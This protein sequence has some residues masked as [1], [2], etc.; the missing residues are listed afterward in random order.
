VKVIGVWDLK[1]G[2]QCRPNF[3]TAVAFQC[4]K[5]RLDAEFLELVGSVQFRWIFCG[6]IFCWRSDIFAAILRRKTV[7]HISSAS[8]Y[9]HLISK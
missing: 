9:I 2:T 1:Q 7:A 5:F 6:G 3:Q 4:A 8:F